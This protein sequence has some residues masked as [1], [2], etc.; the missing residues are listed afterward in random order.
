[1]STSPIVRNC[2]VQFSNL[3]RFM[4][5]II[6]EGARQ[7]GK[8]TL[9]T[10][11]TSLNHA[12]VLDLDD[13]ETY[14]AV[15]FDPRG[16]MRQKASLIMVNEIQRAP[17]LL[18]AINNVVARDSRPAH[19]VITASANLAT[20][21]KTHKALAVKSRTIKLDGYS[22]GERLGRKEDF[23]S[24]IWNLTTNA[25]AALPRPV[26][27]AREDYLHLINTPSYPPA[28]SLIGDD[29]NHW[30]EDY[31]GRVLTGD[32]RENARIRYP[33]RIK[34]IMRTISANTGGI[35][36]N[37]ALAKASGLAPNS[38]PPYLQALQ[39]TYIL[40]QVDAWQHHSL[41]RATNQPKYYLADTGL[42][43]HLS[44]TTT[45]TLAKPAGL[46]LFNTLLEGFVIGEL[47]RQ[48]SW[49]RQTY[50]IYHYR[51]R[52]GRKVDILLE[53]H[54]RQ[55]V[56]IEV[57]AASSLHK[58]FFTGL[59]YLRGKI[60]PKFHAGIVFYTGNHFLS[61]GPKLWAMPIAALWDHL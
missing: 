24:F 58:E 20:Q 56:A 49:S 26:T 38:I 43:L 12:S 34:Q 31:L 45:A 8:R 18:T 61:V 2:A 36:T 42:A 48:R 19:F 9:V 22:R 11:N 3:K 1:M 6:I 40:R 25:D 33:E 7:V 29:K 32:L 44:N 41:K 15:R 60:G 23:A 10:E 51:D 47:S 54:N 50:K 59:Q 4:P 57:K 27:S 39:D 14:H 46:K 30:Y 35:I 21:V 53:N 13:Q 16:F 37:A 52:D 5:V 55:I 17:E 28:A